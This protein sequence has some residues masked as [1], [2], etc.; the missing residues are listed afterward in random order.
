MLSF[1]TFVL[2]EAALPGLRC[3]VIQH[4]PGVREFEF[5][6]QN[7]PASAPESKHRFIPGWLTALLWLIRV[8]GCSDLLLL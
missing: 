3:S 7:K 6:A 4:L 5:H 2:F 8:L 1:T